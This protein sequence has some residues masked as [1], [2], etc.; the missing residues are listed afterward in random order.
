METEEKLREALGRLGYTGRVAA[1]PKELLADEKTTRFL[2]WLT[3][4][5][6]PANFVTTNDLAR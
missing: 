5:L 6:T 2:S 3:Q 1:I 4:Q